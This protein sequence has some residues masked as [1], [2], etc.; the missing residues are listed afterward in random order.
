[1]AGAEASASWRNLLVQGEYYG[2][3]VARAA[4]TPDLRFS[5]WY[6]QAA[7]TLLGAPRRWSGSDGVWMP[8]ASQDGFSPRNGYWPVLPLRLMA[9]FLHAEVAGGPS[10]RTVNAVAGRVAI[11]F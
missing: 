11:Q 1:M 5:G 2:I 9:E 8:T 4:G 6:M 7:Y 3:N 10:A